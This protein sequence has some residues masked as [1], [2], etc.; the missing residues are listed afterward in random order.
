[1][2]DGAEME[3]ETTML[4]AAVGSRM[5]EHAETIRDE[6]AAAFPPQAATKEESMYGSGCVAKSGQKVA[7]F[8][9]KVSRSVM[10][11]SVDE[12]AE[13]CLLP[14]SAA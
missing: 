5:Q 4:L 9:E 6:A 8:A 2:G 12:Q 10:Q 13:A 14:R 11:V 3:V 1:M 7:R